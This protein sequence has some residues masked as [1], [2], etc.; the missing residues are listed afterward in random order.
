M[1]KL[2]RLRDFMLDIWDSLHTVE[3]VREAIDDFM[4]SLG[5]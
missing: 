2:E 1:S 3:E 4:F 5:R